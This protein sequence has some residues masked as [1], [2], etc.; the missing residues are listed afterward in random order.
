MYPYPSECN[1][2]WSS[3]LCASLPITSSM[4]LPSFKNRN[5]GEY[6]LFCVHACGMRIWAMH[7]EPD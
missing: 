3:S 6:R 2:R 5:D 4:T 1:Q 7:V